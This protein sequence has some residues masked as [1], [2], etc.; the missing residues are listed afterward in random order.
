M[1]LIWLDEH[2]I[3]RRQTYT[4]DLSS[5][6]TVFTNVISSVQQDD[7]PIGLSGGGYASRTYT[8]FMDNTRTIN[9]DDR[10]VTSD[11]RELRVLGVKRVTSG[12]EDYQQISCEEGQD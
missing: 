3:V 4:N 6:A 2:I 10:L 8:V 12:G 7:V 1:A 11:G 9:P 5:F